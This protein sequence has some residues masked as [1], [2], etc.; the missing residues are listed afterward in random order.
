M[1]LIVAQGLVVLDQRCWGGRRRGLQDSAAKLNAMAGTL[2]AKM[3][4]GSL[5]TIIA[6]VG[7]PQNAR[8]ALTSPN[9][10]PHTGFLRLAFSDAEGRKQAA[11]LAAEADRQSRILKAEGE[12]AALYLAAQGEAKAV[13]TKFGAIHA[14]KPDPALLAYQYLQTLPQ[15]AQGDANKMWIV[16]SEFSQALEGLA[17]LSGKEGAAAPSWL[18]QTGSGTNGGAAPIDTSSWFDSNLTPAADQPEA[19]G[20]RASDEAAEAGTVGHRAILAP[21]CPAAMVRACGPPGVRC[22]SARWP[23]W[24]RRRAV[25]AARGVGPRRATIVGCRPAALT[26]PTPPSSAS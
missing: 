19:A 14:A 3:P 18:A 5:E 22:W 4:K 24:F 13:E 15:I 9:A 17:G 8:S 10:G 2:D 23:R 20:V 12:R 6:N 26:D 25:R 7:T 16:P 11:I 21:R 1:R